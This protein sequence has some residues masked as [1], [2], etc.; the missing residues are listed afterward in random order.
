MPGSTPAAEAPPSATS[1]PGPLGSCSRSGWKS[2]S[3]RSSLGAPSSGLPRL[4]PAGAPG[5]GAHALKAEVVPL[6]LW[7]P[8]V[9]PTTEAFRVHLPAGLVQTATEAPSLS[10]VPNIRGPSDRLPR[11]V[12]AGMFSGVGPREGCLAA[13]AILKGGRG[14]AIRGP[15]APG[16]YP[17]L[18]GFPP[19][20][21][22]PG[23]G[24]RYGNS[25]LLRAVRLDCPGAPAALP[26]P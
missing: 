17:C 24:G 11:Q 10:P 18:V 16:E 25:G 20:I 7:P 3:R 13:C 15:L 8:K 21:S 23:L 26:A 19:R 4:G 1:L 6:S 12:Y 5:Y 9:R 14:P 22:S 2:S